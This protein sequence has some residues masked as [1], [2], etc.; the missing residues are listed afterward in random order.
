MDKVSNINARIISRDEFD[1]IAPQ[2]ILPGQPAA[3]M[4]VNLLQFRNVNYA[5]GHAVGDSLLAAVE[6]RIGDL[7]PANAVSARIGSK[8]PVALPAMAPDAAM[9]FART[10]S[11]AFERPFQASKLG[12]S[13][14]VYDP[15]HDPHTPERLALLGELRGAV[16][17]GELQ[18]YCQPK[19]DIRSGELT[20]AEA[21]VRW[22]HPRRGILSPAAFVPLL[23]TTDLMMLLT[24]HMLNLSARQVGA[25]GA[26]HMA[27]PLAVNLSPRDVST[28]RLS[29]VLPGLLAQAGISSDTLG[30][31][32]T[33]RSLMQNPKETIA[34]LKR[35]RGLG[36][37]LYVDDFGTG[38]SSL[39]YL[40]DLPIHVLK[41]DCSFTSRMLRDKRAA[42]I[43]RATIGLAHELDLKVVAEGAADRPTWDA[44]AQLGCDQVQGYFVARPF[45]AAQMGA[46]L[47]AA[48]YRARPTA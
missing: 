29:S 40:A 4:I 38:F 26:E 32:V 8:F 12:V 48:P 22:H 23:E 30:L 31:E 1:R 45:P 44:L 21:L 6:E 25:W 37:E 11:A 18:L 7:L 43:V 35:L 46:W 33:E 47:S 13:I 3:F 16:E 36:F 41:I 20:G 19:V 10:L 24:E 28:Q 2:L 39:S 27:I 34:E 5:L 17:R 42:S 9:A 15:A 14:C